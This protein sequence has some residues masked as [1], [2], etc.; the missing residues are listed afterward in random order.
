MMNGHSTKTYNT[1]YINGWNG[2]DFL[3]DPATYL[4]YNTTMARNHDAFRNIPGQ[5]STDLIS[6]AALGFLEDAIA[7]TDR[8]FFIGI[9]PIAPHSETITSTSPAQFNPPVPAKRHG[10]LFPNVTVPR[11][12]GFNPEKVRSLLTLMKLIA[13]IRI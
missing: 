11:T 7:A 4:F 6:T 9:A 10:N 8:P 12:P 2:S 1:P 13:H 3:L 5:Y